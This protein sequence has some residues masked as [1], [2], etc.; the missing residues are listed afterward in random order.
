MHQISEN[1][2]KR[3]LL[4]ASAFGLLT[5]AAFADCVAHPKV[6]SAEKVDGT[7]TTARIPAAEEQMVVAKKKPAEDQAVVTE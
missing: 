6:T 4:T 5:S 1:V 7:M 2:M 3:V